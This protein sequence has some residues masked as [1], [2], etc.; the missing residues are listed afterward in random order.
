MKTKTCQGCGVALPMS[1][2]YQGNPKCKT[3]VIARVREYRKKNLEKIKDYD[4]RRSQL[5]HRQKQNN[6]NSRRMRREI[7]ERILANNQRWRKKNPE[8]YRAHCAVNNALR[9]GRIKRKVR[10]EDCGKKGPLHKHHEDYS[11]PM[12]VI[13]LCVPCHKAA[14]KKKQG[15]IHVR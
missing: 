2:F 6:E 5:P 3:C 9:D 1:E 15:E 12:E 4:R 10:C 13:W 11:K 7:P 14:E 8:K